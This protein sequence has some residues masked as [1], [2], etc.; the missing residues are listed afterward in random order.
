[1]AGR[2]IHRETAL[3]KKLAK[4]WEDLASGLYRA[5]ECSLLAPVEECGMKEEAGIIKLPPR[6]LMNFRLVTRLDQLN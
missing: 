2:E 4:C 3:W 1:M 5:R 6:I